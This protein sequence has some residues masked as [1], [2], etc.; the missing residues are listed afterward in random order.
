MAS[1]SP[2][3]GRETKLDP[4]YPSPPSVASSHT[5]LSS[6]VL[7]VL[8]CGSEWGRGRIREWRLHSVPNVTARF[9]R[10]RQPDWA[11]G[12]SGN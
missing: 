12:V 5:Q 9:R 4:Q 11:I 8:S 6:T 1:R 10:E 3:A 7:L 2:V